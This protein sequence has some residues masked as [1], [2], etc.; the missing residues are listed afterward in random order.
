[1]RLGR[2][3]SSRSTTASREVAILLPVGPEHIPALRA[4]I[5]EALAPHRTAEG[6]YR[7]GTKGTISPA[8][9]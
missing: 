1:V 4:A 8:R 2:G 3:V 9:A 7:L 6:A 5:L